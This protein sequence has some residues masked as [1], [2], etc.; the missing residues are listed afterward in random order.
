MIYIIC[1]Q[2]FTSVH[3]KTKFCFDLYNLHLYLLIYLL[4][5]LY[6]ASIRRAGMSAIETQYYYYY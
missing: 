4:Y 3:L 6:S 5:V 1:I 2:M